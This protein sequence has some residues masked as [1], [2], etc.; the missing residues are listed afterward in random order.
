ML[1]CTNANFRK[2]KDAGAPLP[3]QAGTNL[4]NESLLPILLERAQALALIG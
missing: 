3:C 1:N 4:K 2:Q